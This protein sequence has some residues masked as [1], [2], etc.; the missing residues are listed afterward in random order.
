ME[1]NP[2][3]QPFVLCHEDIRVEW[4]GTRLVLENARIQRTLDLSSGMPATVSLV[5]RIDSHELA[6]ER[7]DEDFSF[8]GYNL[9]HH[10]K[11]KTDFVLP[12]IEAD[13]VAASLLMPAHVRVVMRIHEGVQDLDF[14]REYLLFPGQPFMA[15]RAAIRCPVQP[16]LYWSRRGDLHRNDNFGIA[17]YASTPPER[18]ESAMD[19]LRLAETPERLR[20]VEFMAR[21]DYTNTLVE[22]TDAPPVSCAQRFNGNLCL[23]HLPGERGLFFLQE[24]P[25]SNE[26]RD[27][28]S[29]DFRFDEQSLYSL[30]WGIQPHEVTGEWLWGYRHLLGL[31]QGNDKAA[32]QAI[33]QLQAHRFPR[34]S[35]GDGGI[36]VNPWGCGRFFSSLSETF[37]QEEVNA[38]GQ[39]GATTYQIDDGWEAGGSLVEY[40]R[41]NRATDPSFWELDPQHFPNG[42]EPLVETA[43]AVDVDLGIWLAP[44]SNREHRDWQVL[45]QRLLDLHRRYGIRHF[46]F[47]GVQNRTK[48]AE[49]NLER[50]LRE[51]RLRSQ[52]QALVDF[53]V[54]NGQRQGYLLFQEYGLVFLA[55]R[56]VCHNW[57]MIYHPEITL[58]NVW[59]F[60]RYL[61]LQNLLIECTDPGLINHDY[62]HQK[63][64]E[65]PDCYDADYWAA[66]TLFGNPLLWLAPSRLQPETRETFSRV[67]ALHRQHRAGIFAGDIAPVGPEPDGTSLMGFLSHHQP[68]QSGYLILYRELQGPAEATLSMPVLAD[69]AWRFISLSD[70][71]GDLRLDADSAALAVHLPR[72]GSFRLYRYQQP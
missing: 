18:L 5:D 49:D 10:D 21:T 34:D 61:R 23:C 30:C 62:F 60:S 44:T 65:P 20:L 36:L 41:H 64:V 57:G 48:A 63:G 26:R 28:E 6:A 40:T 8:L 7:A 11:A 56:Y 2:T 37:L 58:H 1:L 4:E 68:Q 32:A 42:L 66:L 43:R 55:N 16:N 33:R 71:T 35:A 27:F 50:L 54:T 67:L 47:D 70:E 72:P 13:C 9:P 14:Q 51:L 25:H 52:G 69:H 24:A 3:T 46:K 59:Q 53:D 15:T 17:E 45:S 39:L 31:F 22:V 19:S 12:T 29:F 38:A